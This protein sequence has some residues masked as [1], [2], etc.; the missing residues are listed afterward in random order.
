MLKRSQGGAQRG[1]SVIEMIFT[2]A[3]LGILTQIAVPS[4]GGWMERQRV[5]SAAESIHAGIQLSRVEALVRNA[6]VRFTLAADGSWSVACV[7]T[8]PG[9]PS[10]ADLHVRNGQETSGGIT[11]AVNGSTATSATSVTYD[12]QGRLVTTEAGRIQQVDLLASAEADSLSSSSA[13]RIVM[14]DFGRTRL[15][16]PHA[17]EG[18]PTRC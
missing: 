6:R 15:C 2:V 16:Y 12:A 14:S 1:I 5:R 7:A 17:S 3:L 9:C 13:T 11:M 10:T 8:S 18:S 4:F